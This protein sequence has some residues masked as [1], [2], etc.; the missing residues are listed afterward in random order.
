MSLLA[1]PVPLDPTRRL[2][3]AQV[4]AGYRTGEVRLGR[5]P[6]W[7]AS[8]EEQVP[9]GP[10]G[11]QVVHRAMATREGGQFLEWARF[12]YVEAERTSG[13]TLVHFIDARYADRP[14]VRFGALTVTVPD[15]PPVLT[16]RPATA[17]PLSAA[18]APAPARGCRPRGGARPGSGGCRRPG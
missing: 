16:A 8:R 9:L 4:P 7:V 14:G 5:R 15:Q 13:G 12:P 17:G 2:I 18:A 10:W 6:A 1:S 3:V 11:S